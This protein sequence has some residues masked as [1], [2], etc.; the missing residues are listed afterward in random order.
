MGMCCDNEEQKTTLL[1]ELLKAQSMSD[2]EIETAVSEVLFGT[3]GCYLDQIPEVHTIDQKEKGTQPDDSIIPFKYPSLSKMASFKLS[4]LL[5]HES[6][7]FKF[8]P[9]SADEWPQ[10]V[11]TSEFEFDES[12][13]SSEQWFPHYIFVGLWSLPSYVVGSLISS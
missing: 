7:H 10:S 1:S 5:S 4:W 3:V 9:V 13:Q 2:S 12:P 8:P 11:A 6:L